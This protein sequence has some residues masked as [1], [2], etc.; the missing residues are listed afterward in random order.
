MH[1]LVAIQGKQYQ[2]SLQPLISALGE[3]VVNVSPIGPDGATNADLL[4][5]FRQQLKTIS[6]P[7][8][9]VT[10][11]TKPWAMFEILLSEDPGRRCLIVY[12]PASFGIA[13]RIE[14]GETAADAA[15]NWLREGR[16]LFEFAKANQQRTILIRIDEALA[17]PRDMLQACADKYMFDLT[18]LSGKP[19]GNA[20]PQPVYRLLG[21]A[22]ANQMPSVR[23]LEDSLSAMALPLASAAE[24]RVGELD[25]VAEKYRLLIKDQAILQRTK[26]EAAAM[27]Q[28]AFLAER[29]AQDLRRQIKASQESKGA[30]TDP[31]DNRAAHVA[32]LEAE[33]AQLRDIFSDIQALAET[34]TAEAASH[35]MRAQNVQADLIQAKA[36]LLEA[37]SAMVS[38]PQAGLAEMPAAAPMRAPPTER[39]LVTKTRFKPRA[40]LRFQQ[41]ARLVSASGL[42]DA[43]WYLEKNADV[44]T[45][46]ANPALHFVRY[47][48]Q[49]GRDAGPDFSSRRYL[50]DNPDVANAGINPLVHYLRLGKAEG[51]KIH[52][53]E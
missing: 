21:G 31:L 13:R 14:A 23:S 15:E 37:R 51:R 27:R 25:Q 24:W 8:L 7:A 34:K 33:V 19:G 46:G 36:E 22:L 28:A 32:E 44:R 5:K 35:R 53:S 9:F 20:L 39:P 30:E 6:S 49:E 41:E 40:W 1:V 29:A 47:G 26:E 42:F 52:R 38:G 10:L 4:A 43:Q 50:D 48:G 18:D 16:G 45:V 17:A 12:E 2:G 11:A 3:R